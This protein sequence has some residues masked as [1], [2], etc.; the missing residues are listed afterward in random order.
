MSSSSSSCDFNEIILDP[1]EKKYRYFN[2]PIEQIPKWEEDKFQILVHPPTGGLHWL[3]IEECVN[4]VTCLTL[5]GCIIKP[6][7]TPIATIKFFDPENSE[8]CDI[9]ISECS[10]SSSS[11]P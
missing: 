9:D 3:T 11:S 2:Q 10:S 8:E 5:D 4:V 6:T 1:S 7:L